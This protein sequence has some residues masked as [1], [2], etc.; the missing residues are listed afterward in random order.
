VGVSW[1]NLGVALYFLG[2]NEQAEDAYEKAIQVLLPAVGAKHPDILTVK[3]NLAFIAEAKNNYKK[4]EKSFRELLKLKLPIVG[5]NHPDLANCQ[6]G[7][8]LA[9][10]GQEKHEEA[11]EQLEKALKTRIEKLGGNHTDVGA[12][13]AAMTV[14]F[15]NQGK[16]DEA[17]KYDAKAREILTKTKG[18]YS[19]NLNAVSRLRPQPAELLRAKSKDLRIP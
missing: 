2:E 11:L 16:F 15:L 1:N 12:T 4:A 10:E 3:T 19:P 5:A 14:I 8:A 6:E 17:N 9:L 7:L 18:T 13:Y